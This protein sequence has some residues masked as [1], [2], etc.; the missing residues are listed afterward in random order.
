M[1]GPWDCAVSAAA[2]AAAVAAL[3]PLALHARH[4]QTQQ[5]AIRALK[6]YA[7]AAATLHR[8]PDGAHEELR[9]A[10][11]EVH[12]LPLDRIVC[13]AG[14]DE[15]I[16]LLVHAYAG[17]GDEVLFSEHGFLMYKI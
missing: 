8:Y 9:R 1:L 11:G 17:P 2:F 10:I 3:A 6:A 4:P 13:G 12:G 14:S 7:E 5:Y 16:G 15:L